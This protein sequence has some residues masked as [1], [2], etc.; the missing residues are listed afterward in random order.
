M[1]DG[2]AGSANQRG[3]F[4]RGFIGT[5]VFGTQAFRQQLWYNRDTGTLAAVTVVTGAR[6]SG[7]TGC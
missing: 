4:G 6:F 2:S 3:I 7:G 1:A 5:I